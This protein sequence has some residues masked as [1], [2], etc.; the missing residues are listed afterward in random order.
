MRK[1]LIV[2][3]A[4]SLLIGGWSTLP[5]SGSLPQ[6]P[7]PTW[8]E[9]IGPLMAASCMTCHRPGEVAP[10]SFLSYD[11]VVPWA[12]SIRMVVADRIMPPWHADPRYGHFSNDRRLT[13]EQIGT[14]LAWIEAGTPRGTGTFAPPTYADG[15]TLAATEGAPDYVFEMDEEWHMPAGGPDIF[16]PVIIPTN[17]TEDLWLR[18]LEAR[19]NRRIVH[20]IDVM[21][22]L[23]GGDRTMLGID[24]PGKPPD[25]FPEGSAV[26]FPAG[27]DLLLRMHYH[28][29]GEEQTNITRVGV[30]L[31]RSPIEYQVFGGTVHDST[32]E[33]PPYAPSVAH[34]AEMVFE[35]EAEL[36]VLQPHM[37]YRGKDMMFE[38][39][40]P[41]GSEE[42]LLSVPNYS[43]YWQMIYKLVEPIRMVKGAKL[44]VTGH[45]DN[46]ANNPWNPNPSLKVLYG[47]DSRDEMFQGWMHY[48]RKLD[49]P[50]VPSLTDL[51]TDTGAS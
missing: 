4:S 46:S 27:A 50:I 42:I 23:R 2:G 49:R 25:F 38:L 48:R 36:L 41:D 30:W 24:L 47:E 40:Q 10:M 43:I 45:F 19:G 20:H 17:H 26:L 31:A 6:E 11:D 12:R 3:V 33:I 9:D 5:A 44:R 22:K 7:V 37:H 8:T 15:W 39:V 18:G 51:T 14:M 35:E 21:S 16:Q 29:N 34:S 32:F 13:D 28:P 1:G